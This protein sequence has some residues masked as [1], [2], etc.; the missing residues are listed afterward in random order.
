MKRMIKY[1]FLPAMFFIAVVAVQGQTTYSSPYSR[2]GLGDLY[3]LSNGMNG[4][5]GGLKYGIRSNFLVNPSNP[6]SYSGFNKHSFV[7]DAG[8]QGSMARMVSGVKTRD[9]G[10]FG[11]GSMSFGVPINAKWNGA[12]GLV[13]YSSVGYAISD[14]GFDST[15]G[16]YNS[17]FEGNGGLN[18]VFAGTSYNITK[19]LSVGIN[20]NFMFGSLNY[21][22]T[23]T[24]DSINFL[25]LMSERSRA[26]N[27]LCFD[28]GVQY[29]H[30]LN[31]E[32][33]MFLLAGLAV[34]LPASL[35]THENLLTKTFKYSGSGVVIVKD[36]VEY[37]QGEKGSVN[38]PMNIA[39]GL[40]LRRGDRWLAGVDFAMQDWSKFEALGIKD[41]L[42]RSMQI[43]I[44]GQYKLDKILIR[45]G[46]RFQQTYLQ[47]R[48]NQLSEY[49]ISF[50][51]GLPVYNKAYSIS[52]ISAGVEL[53]QRGTS[54][55]E[56]IKEH[57]GRIWL[58]FTMNQDRWFKR[59][60]YL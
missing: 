3:Q 6:A 49:G 38:I 50:G 41:S 31:E 2:F 30:T 4:A 14:P 59:R 25:N 18:R 52:M 26:I 45:G 54:D 39:G 15:F 1:V 20:A 22:Q 34:S 5:M 51:V 43:A 37:V 11:L 28:A 47:I 19:D 12:F 60:E 21:L 57:F 13:P 42:A 36:T 56:L 10:H 48:E 58:S 24:F 23:V 16:G 17:I 32:R 55:S 40:S 29:Q 9:D 44:G 7:F 53:G 27:D 46:F 35:N 33:E 8:L